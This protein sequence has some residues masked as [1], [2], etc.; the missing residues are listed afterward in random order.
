MFKTQKINKIHYTMHNVIPMGPTYIPSH[1]LH[2]QRDQ[3][4][5]KWRSQ[6]GLLSMVVIGASPVLR[7]ESDYRDTEAES[8]RAVTFPVLSSNFQPMT[9]S[10]GGLK[11]A[12]FVH[13]SHQ[14]CFLLKS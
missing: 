9:K 2:L 11:R 12:I 7:L 13:F 14:S 10:Y 8:S 1:V 5:K 3:V 6:R 4:T